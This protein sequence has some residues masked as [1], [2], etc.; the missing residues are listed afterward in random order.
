MV[1]QPGVVFGFCILFMQTEII[2]ALHNLNSCFINYPRDTRPKQFSQ[3]KILVTCQMYFSS[4]KPVMYKLALM[5]V[6]N[7]VVETYL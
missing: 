6:T 5:E 4:G 2:S 7:V 3:I 1:D